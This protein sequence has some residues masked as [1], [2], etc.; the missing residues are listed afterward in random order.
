PTGVIPD[1]W[2][3]DRLHPC[4]AGFTLRPRRAK[5]AGVSGPDVP[6]SSRPRFLTT[7]EHAKNYDHS[8][9]GRLSIGGLS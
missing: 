2:P 7:P 6:H 9:F 8:T 5:T 3:P 4:Q 1:T